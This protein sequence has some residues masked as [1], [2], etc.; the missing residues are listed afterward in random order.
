MSYGLC[1]DIFFIIQVYSSVQGRNFMGAMKALPA[2]PPQFGH[3][4][5]E[6]DMP[7]GHSGL[8]APPALPQLIL[9]FSPLPCFP[10]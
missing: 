5:L 2:V 3:M 8:D 6:N 9:P 7:Y 1:P 10:V 4:P